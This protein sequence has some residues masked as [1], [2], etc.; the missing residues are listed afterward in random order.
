MGDCQQ[1]TCG[2]A[3]LFTALLPALKRAHRHTKQL[4]ELRLRQT[5]AFA[6]LDG[7]RKDDPSFSGFHLPHGLKQLGGKITL[8][9]IS[10]KLSISEQFSFRWHGESP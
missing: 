5:G 9:L 8:G 3:W 1:C 4:G 2:P 7:G 6:R 10:L